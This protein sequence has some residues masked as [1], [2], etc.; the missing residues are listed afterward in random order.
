MHSEADQSKLDSLRNSKQIAATVNPNG[1]DA[2][3]GATIRWEHE[4]MFLFCPWNQRRRTA[5]LEAEN[6]ALKKENKRLM[7]NLDTAIAKET[8]EASEVAT[9]TAKLT[10]LENEQTGIAQDDPRWATLAS[11]QATIK[12]AL[13]AALNPPVPVVADPAAPTA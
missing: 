11:E 8:A 13:D 4:N 2:N 3:T 10:A 1:G 5:R 6:A 9:L 7:D 12:A